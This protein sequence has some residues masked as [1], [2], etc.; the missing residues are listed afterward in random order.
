M[1]VC[2][3]GV[4]KS[5]PCTRN[6]MIYLNNNN[7]LNIQIREDVTSR[8]DCMR[9]RNIVYFYYF[10]AP[11]TSKLYRVHGRVIN[12]YGGV[13][14]MKIGRGSLSIRRKP[15]PMPHCT[16]QIQHDLGSNPGRRGWK[17][18]ANRLRYGKS[19]VSCV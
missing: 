13:D 3:R 17:A 15:A 9:N 6:S 7:D 18:G 16:P 10:T 14:G 19:T 5:G 1:Y 4:P 2:I 12:E 8:V 11:S